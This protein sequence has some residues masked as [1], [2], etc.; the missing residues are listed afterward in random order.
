MYASMLRCNL[1]REAVDYLAKLFSSTEVEMMMCHQKTKNPDS[2][3]EKQVFPQVTKENCACS[4]SSYV[5]M[6]V[7][8]LSDPLLT[9]VKTINNIEFTL[10]FLPFFDFP[11]LELSIPPPRF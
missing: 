1:T 4:V 8:F 3:P 11:H 2:D 5:F 9:V 10:Y 7:N 6:A